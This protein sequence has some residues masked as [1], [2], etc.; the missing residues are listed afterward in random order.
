MDQL[1][2]CQNQNKICL[3]FFSICLFQEF[4]GQALCMA[5]R[6]DI[7]RGLGLPLGPALT[8]YRMVVKLQTR[9]DDWTMCWG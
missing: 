1:I 7:V 5:R 4:D 2:D 6:V 8:L 9:V 3:Y